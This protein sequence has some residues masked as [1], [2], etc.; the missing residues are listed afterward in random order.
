MASQSNSV[1]DLL[2][3]L[4]E[5]NA[6]IADEL[7]RVQTD[8]QQGGEAR[9][10]LAT[11]DLYQ[12]FDLAALER[13]AV[14]HYERKLGAGWVSRGSFFATRWCCSRWYSHGSPCSWQ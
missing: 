1:A 6:E 7:A 5:F 8:I 9:G 14:A 12:V 10:R 4:K 11:L 2:R 13:Q 3:D